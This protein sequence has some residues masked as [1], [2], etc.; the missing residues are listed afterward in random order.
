M[1]TYLVVSKARID[2][3][4]LRPIV[5]KN[6]G[7]WPEDWNNGVLHEGAASI[8]INV[9]ELTWSYSDEELEVLEK[10]LGGKPVSSVGV[11]YSWNDESEQLA[12]QFCNELIKIFGGY[13]EDNF[14][15]LVPGLPETEDD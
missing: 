12:K 15:D 7:H 13:F 2:E 10:I 14:T 1:E 3:N 11:A 4:V 8:Y 9:E 6:G 5:I